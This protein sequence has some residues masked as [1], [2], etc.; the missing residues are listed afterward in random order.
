MQNAITNSARAGAL[1]ADPITGQP[2]R[3]SA[4]PPGV[5]HLQSNPCRIQGRI[6][7]GLLF[8]IRASGVGM[9]CTHR[10][11]FFEDAFA[12]TAMNI[13]ERHERTSR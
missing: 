2:F 6:G 1:P 3:I 7:S 10:Q 4:R 13:V 8:A 12:L 11:H 9:E 5:D